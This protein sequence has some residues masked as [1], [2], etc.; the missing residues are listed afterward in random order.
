VSKVSRD[1]VAN[2]D[3]LD[4]VDYLGFQKGREQQHKVS[5]DGKDCEDEDVF[6]A[7]D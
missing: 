5:R 4:Q 2:N 6:S 7:L 1:K 3:S